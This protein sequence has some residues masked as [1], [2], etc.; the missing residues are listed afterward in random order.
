MFVNIALKKYVPFIMLW[1]LKILY[2]M[3][4][5]KFYFYPLFT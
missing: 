3:D 1:N 5:F 2:N 4:I